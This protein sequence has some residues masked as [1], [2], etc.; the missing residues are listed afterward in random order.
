LTLAIGI[1]ANASVFSLINALLLRPLPF[2]D[3]AR[4]VWIENPSSGGEGI[5]GLSGQATYRDWRALNESFDDLGAYVPSLSERGGY[6][7]NGNGE[8]IELRAA[9]VSSNLLNLLGIQAQP[10]RGFTTEECQ[11]GGPNGVILTERFWRYQYAADPA[12]L[13][14]TIRISG[15]SHLVVGILPEAFES[16]FSSV[17]RPGIGK[18][19][20]LLPFRS[21]PGYDNWGNM[22]AV[23]G[24][25]KRG[26]GISQ[27]QSEF[28]VLNRQ[29]QTAHPERGRFAARLLPLSEHVTG[30]YRHSLWLLAAAV[31]AVLL[32]ACVNLSSLLLA[33]GASRERELSVRIALGAGR[34]RLVRQMLTESILLSMIGGLVGLPLT[35]VITNTVAKT[36]AVSLPLLD[37]VRVDEF[38]LTVI[39]LATLSTGLLFGIVPALALSKAASD[40]KAAGR[41]STQGP[42]RM[43]LNDVLVIAEVALAFVLLIGAGLLI[44]SLL[45]LLEV[46]PGFQAAHALVCRIQTHRQFASQAEWNVFYQD[47]LLRVQQIPGVEAA[48]LPDKLPLALNDLVRVRPKD[49]VRRGIEIPSVLAQLVDKTYFKTLVIPL[50]GGRSFEA[51]D[52]PFDWQG[53]NEQV[54]IVNQKMAREF[55]G[56]K[57]AVGKVVVV[58]S[59]PNAVV[60]CRLVGVVGNVRQSALDQE[61]GP[62]I[63]LLGGGSGDLVVRTGVPFTSMASQIRAVLHQIDPQMV[64]TAFRPLGQILEQAVAPKRLITS[65]LSAFSLAALALAAIGVFGV[66]AYS[67]SQRTKEIGI[68]LALGSSPGAVVRLILAQGIRRVFIGCVIGL[69]GASVLTQGLR[70]F[71][72]EVSPTDPVTMALACLLV[73][74]T[75]L[76]ASWL[77]ARKASKV[78]PLITLRHE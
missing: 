7:L 26:T 53:T 78:D 68:R 38:A 65:W 46:D 36:H 18:P 50:R 73:V 12:L 37:S 49:E 27:A 10:G 70:S 52:P 55:W 43:R 47:L 57:D 62:E 72:F 32:I 67:T 31:A 16:T 14:R 41:S 39:A 20:I 34:W 44:H 77:P 33:R 22:L 60:E 42:Q 54:A 8:P 9:C 15:V 28:D 29:L 59:A 30:S 4:L 71:L 64:V 6:V 56:S 35:Y 23:V 19:D 51:H 66:A 76:V 13:G 2:R 58:E 24:R 45:R 40:L 1:G 17:F 3:S 21:A 5:P 69:L 61:A 74:T 11:R 75:G 48:T 25:L 63:Y